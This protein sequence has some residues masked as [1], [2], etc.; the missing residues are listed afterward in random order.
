VTCGARPSCDCIGSRADACRDEDGR[1]TLFPTRDVP[2]CNECSAQEY[3]SI[4]TNPIATCRVV[5][6][7]CEGTP[8]CA[9]FLGNRNRS[10]HYAC[11]DQSGHIVASAR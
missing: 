2:N 11:S 8:T 1:I 5:P 4:G 10:A 7:E 9:C 3:C 6:P